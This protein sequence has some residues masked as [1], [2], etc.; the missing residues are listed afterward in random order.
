MDFG[1]LIDYWFREDMNL[2]ISNNNLMASARRLFTI[3]GYQTPIPLNCDDKTG[4]WLISMC[5]RLFM[6]LL[7]HFAKEVIKTSRIRIGMKFLDTAEL[8]QDT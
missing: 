5:K 6:E 2:T 3:T 7:V 1:E 8:A 4:I